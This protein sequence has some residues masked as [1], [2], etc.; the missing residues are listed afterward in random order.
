MI[1]RPTEPCEIC[2][3]RIVWAVI[4]SGFEC[5]FNPGR[6][7]GGYPLTYG[8]VSK[9]NYALMPYRKHSLGPMPGGRLVHSIHV[10]GTR[11]QIA[12][13]GPDLVRKGRWPINLELP[14]NHPWYGR[15][16]PINASIE[17]DGS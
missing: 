6:A 10:C 4:Q 1:D 3:S 15:I 11:W 7:T 17:G 5:R 13:T 8:T 9:H 2:G 14:P 16:L 12:W